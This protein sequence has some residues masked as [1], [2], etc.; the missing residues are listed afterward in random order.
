[1]NIILLKT[2]QCWIIPP[3]PPSITQTGYCAA[4]ESTLHLS[5]WAMRGFRSFKLQN[6]TICPRVFWVFF[7]I[8]IS[9]S[10]VV[11]F[12]PNLALFAFLYI[13]YVRTL[14]E[15]TTVIQFHCLLKVKL[16]HKPMRLKWW[17]LCFFL[18]AEA[19]VITRRGTHHAW[20][21]CSGFRIPKN[22]YD[23]FFFPPRAPLLGEFHSDGITLHWPKGPTLRTNVK[24]R[25]SRSNRT[26]LKRR[27]L[28]TA[29]VFTIMFSG[30]RS[31]PSC[32]WQT[33]HFHNLQTSRIC[34][35]SRITQ[36]YCRNSLFFLTE[37]SQECQVFRL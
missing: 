31:L 33:R 30:Q 29:V 9:K 27:P 5:R 20:M 21:H 10:K 11:V 2:W 25:S 24:E 15:K 3:A 13:L 17:Q 32:E 23:F 34:F 7:N 14:A 28:R 4:A 8:W 36:C 37:K 19:K 26:W 1:M 12:F 35:S 18:L 6:Q 16:W 22:Q